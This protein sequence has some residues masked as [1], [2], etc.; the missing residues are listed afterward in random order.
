MEQF[1]HE[2]HGGAATGRFRRRGSASYEQVVSGSRSFSALGRISASRW[3]GSAVSTKPIAA[4]RSALKLDPA[5]NPLR[6]NLA[7]AFYK[8]GDRPAGRRG[9]R[10]LLK[11]IPA[12]LR[13]RRC[14]A[15]AICNSASPRRRIAVA[16][17]VAQAPSRRS[18]PRLGARLGADRSRETARG[19]ASG[20]ARRERSATTP[21][22]IS[23]PGRRG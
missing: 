6:M 18:G 12:T 15:I 20:G 9:I 14:W 16:A 19:L 11:A 2:R 1:V 23:W 17:P 5:N 8:K 4:Y 10:A 3:S 7:L 22:R 21:R 13:S